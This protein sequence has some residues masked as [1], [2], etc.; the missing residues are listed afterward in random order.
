MNHFTSL[1]VRNLLN[2]D[3]NL[4]EFE[5]V[6][7]EAVNHIPSYKLEQLLGYENSSTRTRKTQETASSLKER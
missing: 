2:N 5:N 6:L 3:H 7:E 1:L 4:P